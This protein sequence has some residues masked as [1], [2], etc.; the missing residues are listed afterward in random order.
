MLSADL[1]VGTTGAA[2][3]EGHDGV[4]PGTVCI[5]VASAE[6]TTASGNVFAGGRGRVREQ[7]VFA[8]LAMVLDAVLALGED[9][10]T[11]PEQS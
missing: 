7:A 10:D 3:P 11:A 8:A 9:E 6:A 2:G 4:A 5:A 1:G